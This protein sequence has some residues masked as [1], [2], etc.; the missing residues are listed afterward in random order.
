MASTFP[1]SVH[2]KALVGVLEG[3]GEAYAAQV[4][5]ARWLGLRPAETAAATQLLRGS[6]RRGTRRGSAT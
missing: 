5:T 6:A 4:W 2:C 3:L 1:S